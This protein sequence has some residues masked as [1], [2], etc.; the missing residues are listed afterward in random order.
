ML[1]RRIVSDRTAITATNVASIE[2]RA[3]TTSSRAG[4]I[5]TTTIAIIVTDLSGRGRVEEGGQHAR[6]FVLIL[7]CLTPI[8][9]HSANTKVLVG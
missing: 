6:L 3:T 8:P 5:G 1:L 2:G 4:A 9:V 7:T